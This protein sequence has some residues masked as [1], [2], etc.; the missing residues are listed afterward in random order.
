MPLIPIRWLGLTTA[1]L[2]LGLVPPAYADELPG[3]VIAIKGGHFVP[4]EVP[5]PAGKKVKLIVR[6]QDATMSEF[7]SS[8]FH[9]EKVV[10]PGGE[11]SVYVG[12][13]DAGSYEFFDDFHPEDR[14]HLV[15]K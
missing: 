7:E 4:T 1:I 10:P 3:I 6:N 11:I 14:G 12:P 15:V 8:D 9:R 2:A 5:V 13:L